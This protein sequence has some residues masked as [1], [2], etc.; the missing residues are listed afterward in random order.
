MGSAGRYRL[1]IGLWLCGFV[2]TGHAQQ[3][4]YI[5]NRQL[6]YGASY[7]PEAWNLK[8]IGADIARMKELHMNVMRMGEFSWAWMEPREGVYDFAWLKKIMDTLHQNGIDVILGTPTATPPAW[9]ASKYP[10]IFQVDEDGY[11]MEHGARRNT[12]YASEKYRIFSRRICE[13]MADALGAHP[14]L[15]GWQT[16]NEFN[17]APDYSAETRKRWHGWLKQKFGTI[18][19]LNRQWVTQLWSQQYDAFEQIPMPVK[20]VWHHPSLLFN[21]NAFNNDLI[22]E[23]QDIQL[24]A[25]RKYSK[26]P[27]THDGMPGQAVDYEKL[28]RNLDFMAVNNYH[29]F[30]AYDLIQSNYDRMRGYGKGMHWLFETAPN[31]SGGGAKG[32]TW[33]LHQPDGSLH[34]ALWMNY[35][36]GGQ[37]AMYWLWRQ[38]PA[39]QEMVHGSVLSAWGKPAANY[40]DIKQLGEDLQKASDFLMQA[41]VAPAKAAMVWCHQNLAGL[42]FENYASG[43]DYYQDWTYRFY[44]PY[45][46]AYIHRDVIAQSASLEP[47]KLL[48]V[49]LAPY[50]TADLRQ[51]LKEWVHKGGVLV[52]GPMSGYRTEEWTSFTDAALGDLEQWT[53]IAVDSRIPVGTKPRP[54]EIPIGLSFADGILKDSAVAGL[55]SEALS[56]QSGTVLATYTNGMH[57]GLPA[58]M[59]SKYGKGKIL[60]LGT[61][62]GREAM[63]KLLQYSSQAAGLTPLAVGDPE[64]VVVPRI[65]K[66][67]KGYVVIN[68]SNK[69]RSIE[70]QDTNSFVNVLNGKLQ[71]SVSLSLKPYEVMV[72]K[73]TDK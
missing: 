70:I 41:P 33:F 53:G 71:P 63:K 10:E 19:N 52:L 4:A 66:D 65:G 25:I 17:L 69:P 7:Y 26:V 60:I 16:D 18:E 55:W 42:S 40:Q 45:A 67:V 15:I 44:R 31:Y 36:L 6:Y 8:G 24:N 47:Y 43:L 50:L 5:G 73:Q 57:K 59:E 38:H 32:H 34:A 61:D 23:F 2:F 1:I 39:G 21:W 3:K 11:R 35:A 28:F 13:N 54:A 56:S 68:I 22:V 64:V 12:S 14:A 27:V 30:E 37:G 46:D 9:M 49:P 29:S 20:K 51:R 72:L 48:F 62:P 58:I